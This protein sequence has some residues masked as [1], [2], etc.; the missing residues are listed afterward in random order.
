VVSPVLKVGSHVWWLQTYNPVGYGP[1]VSQTFTTATGTPG[2]AT[3]LEPNNTA[4][5]TNYTPTYKWSKVDTVTS[6]R[7]QV[8]GPGNAIVLDKWYTAS[9][10][11]DVP[12]AGV[13]SVAGPTLKAGSHTWWVQTYNPAGYGPWASQNFS[14][15]T[16][17][18]A[19]ATLLEPNNTAP[20]TNYTPTYKWNKVD[21]ATYYRLLVRGPGNVLVLDKWYATSSVCD[22]PIV[23]ECSVV[24]PAL[25]G[26]SQVWWM[27]TYNPAG[28][29][30]WASQAF[31]TVTGTPGLAVLKFP[32]PDVPGGV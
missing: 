12:T 19:G 14:T 2:G 32:V 10:I 21:K 3:L 25:K 1:W 24:S 18:P 4:P 30:P 5:L 11:C 31:S 28:Y 22:V 15:S 16:D 17:T 20:L 7:L 6:Y 27:Q 13:C 8:V 9:T 29:G 26:G 23:G